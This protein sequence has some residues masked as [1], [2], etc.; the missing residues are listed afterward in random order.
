MV[1]HLGAI[2][3]LWGT[4]NTLSSAPSIKRGGK[5][6]IR[7]CLR[8]GPEVA[9]LGAPPS[10]WLIRRIS[11][12]LNPRRSWAGVLGASGRGSVVPSVSALYLADPQE[13]GAQGWLALV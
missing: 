1:V 10:A 2:V 9:R 4:K 3:G 8:G 11:E 13:V 6:H 7:G 5:R 12:A